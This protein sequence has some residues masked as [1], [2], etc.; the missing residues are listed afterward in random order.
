M[1]SI[2]EPK[3]LLENSVSCWQTRDI[4]R[5]SYINDA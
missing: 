4:F 1:K 2:P 3:F 5:Q